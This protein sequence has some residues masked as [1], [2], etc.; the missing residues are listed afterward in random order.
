MK[1]IR[2]RL[3]EL[4][5][6]EYKEFTAKFLPKNTILYGVRLPLI[7]QIAKEALKEQGLAFLEQADYGIYEEKLV[8]AFEIGSVRLPI[9]EKLIFIKNFV[10]EIDNWSICDSFCASFKF[11]DTEKRQMFEFLQPYLNAQNEYEV[12]FGI[13]MLLDHFINEEYIDK[14]LELLKNNK[15][16]DY[17]A[18]M[19]AAWAVSVCMVY[20]PQQTIALLEE[21]TLCTFVQNKAIQKSVESYRIDEKIKKYIKTLKTGGKVEIFNPCKE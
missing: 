19:A 6:P 2:E 13:V 21:K 14:V 11:K 8:C 1:N 4:A 7:H 18:Q 17:Y 9:Q 15:C 3:L 12:R 20:F 16:S 10:P 5:E